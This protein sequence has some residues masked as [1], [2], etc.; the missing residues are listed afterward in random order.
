[1]NSF[2]NDSTTVAT[3]AVSKLNRVISLPMLVFYG[4]G[5][6][7][8]AGIFALSGEIIGISGDFAPYSF[9]LAALIAGFTAVSYSLLSREAP[10]AA[11]EAW[12][13]QQAFGQKASVL[14]GLMLVV[15][16]I[17]SSAAITV[18]FSNYIIDIIALPK[19]LL[20]VMVLVSLS[21]VAWKGVKE[22]VYF[23]AVITLIEVGALLVVITVGMPQVVSSQTIDTII[24]PSIGTAG[25]PMIFS[26][27]VVA[28]FAFI[29]FEDIVNMGEETID[30]ERNL[31]IA[32]LVTLF[33]T[34]LIYTLVSIVCVAVP[35]RAAFL[36]ST[37]PLAY[38]YES[39][40][41]K[42]AWAISVCAAVAMV[43]GI[44]VQIVM[45]SRV[46]YGLASSGS[47]PRFLGRV[48]PRTKTPAIAISLVT[49]LVLVLSLSLRLVNLAV[50]SSI[51][52]LV[53]FSIVNLS[54][55]RRASVDANSRF[56]RW[57]YWG[58]L[59]FLA[60][61]SLLAWQLFNSAPVS[62]H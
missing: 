29:G 40:T 62:G 61:V 18:S 60:C 30:A 17:F 12:F 1:M 47:L 25:L 36:E 9:L 48:D 53:V 7:V 50:Y 10:R 24:A 55:Y 31:P 43:N 21:L 28:F 46:L 26:G 41:G 3:P 22:T 58:L 38:V 45:S 13:V 8:G 2:L 54:L 34:L 35:D 6:T 4:V 42:N 16:A 14:V 20:M 49:L 51:V 19:Q 52:L 57:K 23:A 56:K 11:G 27:A 37:A 39:A 15:S 44:L 59:S 33:F 5:V 32:I